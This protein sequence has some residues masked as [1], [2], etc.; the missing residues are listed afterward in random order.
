MKARLAAKWYETQV[1]TRSV[2]TWRHW[3]TISRD[4]EA[5]EDAL[6]ETKTHLAARQTA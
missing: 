3:C 2:R 1:L 4:A 5:L 6:R